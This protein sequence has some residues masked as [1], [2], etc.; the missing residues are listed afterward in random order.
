MIEWHFYNEEVRN[1]LR[2][3]FCTNVL[4]RRQCFSCYV[5]DVTLCVVNFNFENVE[6]SS[7]ENITSREKWLI[8][9]MNE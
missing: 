3:L 9:H 5:H 6:N 4:S 1:D 8:M 2:I 7:R